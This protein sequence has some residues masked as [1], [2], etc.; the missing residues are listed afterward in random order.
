M[1]AYNKEDVVELASCVYDTIIQVK[2]YSV[3]VQ[4][5]AFR[6]YLAG[7]LRD[8][9]AR[10][11]F[12]VDKITPAVMLDFEQYL[13]GRGFSDRT[14]AVHCRILRQVLRSLDR[15][16]NVQPSML[17][18]EHTID[19]TYL[20]VDELMQMLS[21]KM[22]SERLEKIRHLF[23]FSC[24]TG[25][26]Y[27]DMRAL[28]PTNLQNAGKYGETLVIG[29]RLTN[30]VIVIPL[31]EVPQKIIM[32]YSHRA[33]EYLL[34]QIASA[35]ANAYIKEVAAL[36]GIKKNI[37]LAVARRTF[38]STVAFANGISAD[39]IAHILGQNSPTYTELSAP[40]DNE[41]IEDSFA[42]LSE[43]L[44]YMNDAFIV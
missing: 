40:V 33:T 15:R 26:R 36:C 31:L 37:T 20:S 41:E 14:I 3:R 9:Y 43:E 13:R 42:K 11:Y 38:A 2:P 35:T 34:P 21:V 22:P 27:D 8:R 17:L 30:N 24:F 28:S 44:I 6:R 39:T 4:Y 16:G 25:L 18:R 12:S 5:D 32:R 7:F 10:T 1:R 29:R 19:R 23:L